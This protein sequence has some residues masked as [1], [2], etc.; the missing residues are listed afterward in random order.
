MSDA[1]GVLSTASRPCG[2]G[3]HRAVDA[4]QPRFDHSFA[5]PIRAIPTDL[6]PASKESRRHAPTSRGIDEDAALVE[7]FFTWPVGVCPRDACICCVLLRASVRSDEGRRNELPKCVA[8]VVFLHPSRRAHRV[9]NDAF[10]ICDDTAANRDARRFGSRG[11]RLQLCGASTGQGRIQ[12][13]RFVV[14]IAGHS[15]RRIGVCRVHRSRH[16]LFPLDRENER[17]NAGLA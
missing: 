2:N 17:L 1:S 8:D 9:H 10:P 14:C 16:D 15:P 11:C 5:R 4:N 7:F 6:G 12:F 3:R 13:T